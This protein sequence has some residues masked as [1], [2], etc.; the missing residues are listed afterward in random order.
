[1]MG[2]LSGCLDP[3]IKLPSMEKAASIHSRFDGNIQVPMSSTVN[4]DGV[5]SATFDKDSKITQF[6]GAA[7]N[8]EISGATVAFPPGALSVN[9]TITV[10]PGAPIATQGVVDY[11]GIAD[12]PTIKAAGN[13]VVIQASEKVDATKPFT[14]ALPL[15]V[16]G[17]RLIEEQK[18]VMI[19][20]KVYKE[21]SN[22]VIIGI[23]P[24]Q[25]IEVKE[26]SVVFSTRFFGSYQAVYTD[27]II[28][29]APAEK[30]STTPI[31]TKVE[32]KQLP[33]IAWSTIT[34]TKSVGARSAIFSGSVTGLT[35]PYKCAIIVDRD[36]IFP[37]DFAQAGVNIA[38]AEAAA[39]SNDEHSI[40]AR[41]ECEDSNARV[42][43][44]PWSDKV[45]FA[46]LNGTTPVVAI[47]VNPILRPSSTAGS[48]TTIGGTASEGTTSVVI[49]IIDTSA[50]NGGTCLNSSKTAFDASCPNNMQADGTTS[51][52]ISAADSAFIHNHSYVIQAY[53]KNARGDASAI[54][55]TAF[56]WLNG[57]QVVDKTVFSFNSTPSYG[58]SDILNDI[59]FSSTT[60]SM[61]LLGRG[62][63]VVG[64][65]SGNDWWIRKIANDGTESSTFNFGF[66]NNNSYS[67][68]VRAGAIDSQGNLIAVGVGYNLVDTSSSDDWWI[69]KISPYG[70]VLWSQAYSTPGYYTYD[71]ANAVQVDAND[72]IY[73]AGAGYN[74]TNGTSGNDVWVQKLNP[75]G[76]KLSQFVASSTDGGSDRATSIIVD[77]VN[78]V[79]VGATGYNVASVSSGSDWWIF[80]LNSNLVQ[81]SEWTYDGGNNY[82]VGV[83]RMA[84][85]TNNEPYAMGSV[86]DGHMQTKV[87]RLLNSGTDFTDFYTTADAVDSLAGKGLVID[88]NNNVYINASKNVV[89]VS[90]GTDW[91]ISKID[92]TGTPVWSGVFDNG[93]VM[94]SNDA[95]TAMALNNNN[96]LV[97]AGSA[98]NM[99]SYSS[100]TDW[101]VG[102]FDPAVQNTPIRTKAFSS[103]SP[104][105]EE[106]KSFAIAPNGSY[107]V[108]GTAANL[109]NISSGVD[110]WVR[111]YNENGVMQWSKEYSA[112]YGY[113]TDTPRSLIIDAAEN[114]YVAGSGW[115]LVSSSS[116]EDW[117]IKKLNSAGVEDTANWD[118]TFAPSSSA[119]Y[120]NDA[121]TTMD[122]DAQG[123]IYVGGYVSRSDGGMSWHIKKFTSSGSEFTGG[124]PLNLDD[125]V[126]YSSCR[127]NRL[128][129]DRNS[130]NIYL[131]GVGNNLVDASSNMDW[132]I[133]RY[134]VNGNEAAGWAGGKKFDGGATMCCGHDDMPNDIAIDSSGYIYVAGTATVESGSSS[135]LDWWIKKLNPSDGSEVPGWN[136]KLGGAYQQDEARSIAIDGN[137]D[138]YVVGNQSLYYSSDGSPWWIHRFKSDGTEDTSW[139]ATTYSEKG[140]AN[141]VVIGANGDI[142][143]GGSVR[144]GRPFGGLDATIMRIAAP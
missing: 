122:M 92:N 4:E 54:V 138:V 52:S 25:D 142:Y 22:D 105:D 88:M 41:F 50:P 129:I 137:N 8:S 81:Q 143:V 65:S 14:L 96:Q 60:N 132:W 115:G 67:D 144:S 78:N 94:Y 71:E 125:G 15:S 136:K 99:L 141:K 35:Q 85:N 123:N 42:T 121:A 7:A 87:M 16:N 76:A 26:N 69:K 45:S 56:A 64:T 80:K 117:W 83:T 103:E 108:T 104:S 133:R 134:D 130:Q 101:V 29:K 127:L 139:A 109:T 66:D 2:W 119:S 24:A 102:W 82:G 89:N 1:M 112:P 114:V 113:S 57:G 98:Y 53:G 91:W 72:N 20:Y 107:Y 34:G 97:A 32:D 38:S 10:E 6:V 3:V 75:V 100:S 30:P 135:S 18:Y 140:F 86:L 33:A 73:V 51:W 128:K 47:A 21:G 131:V 59:I 19:I 48:Q 40:T 23:I 77:Q 61:Y 106:T 44:S 116:Y 110:W 93:S 70:S 37:W 46:S 5:I 95:P 43:Q 31:L 118:K 11:L 62:Y 90:S 36:Q 68:D 17:L 39:V 28:T 58:G 49:S 111:K 27:K 12:A 55:S 13:A 120:T 126:P 63:S 9:A 124:W 79:W 84:L 74:L